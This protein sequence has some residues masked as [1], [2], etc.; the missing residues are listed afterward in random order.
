MIFYADDD[1]DDLDFFEQIATDLD[2]EVLTFQDGESL[3]A[4]L[5]NP[6]PVAGIVF[7]DINMPRLS[8]IEVLKKIRSSPAWGRLP[9]VMFSTSSQEEQVNRCFHAGAN[10]YIVKS[11]N[12]ESL[13]K[14]VQVALDTDWKRFTPSLTEFL[15][16]G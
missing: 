13:K 6:P 15:Y 10:L 4:Q 12:L 14:S 5:K 2:L 7:L 3:L 9:V 1:T 16:R 11:P 8:G